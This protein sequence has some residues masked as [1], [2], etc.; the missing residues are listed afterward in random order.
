MM[1]AETVGVLSFWGAFA[2]AFVGGFLGSLHCVGMCGAFASVQGLRG[3]RVVG[4]LAYQVGRL[5]TYSALAAL[6]GLF[7][8]SL[9]RTGT[10]LQLQ[11]VTAIMM[12]LV[13]VGVGLSWSFNWT[14]LA[15]SRHLQAL[16][17]SIVAASREGGAITGP[18]L[19]GASSTLL[20]C[21]FLYGFALAAL[22]TGSL[23]GASATMLG[24]W[25]G[26]APAL[27]ATSLVAS[28]AGMGLMR[29]AKR[30][31]G[32]VM[33]L[34]GLF[35]IAGRL[36]GMQHSHGMHQMSE[37]PGGHELHQMPG[38]HQMK[39][40]TSPSMGQGSAPRP[41]A[42]SPESTDEPPTP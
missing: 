21:G 6:A 14:P 3:K 15:S 1:H 26:T 12:G 38:T 8:E 27:I 42:G 5:L 33:I 18:L 9:V 34:L 4:S 20:P 31:L 39:S 16:T 19:L 30:G 24:F 40:G 37:M 13:L 7:G 32:V 36:P 25:L 29:Y 23:L 35:G 10:W 28:V 17:R 11:W 2:F 22:A 41:A